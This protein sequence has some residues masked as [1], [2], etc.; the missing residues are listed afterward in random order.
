MPI[1]PELP[2]SFPLACSESQA[3][4]Q[5]QQ[6]LDW[7]DEINNTG[8]TVSAD[9]G[10]SKI[11]IGDTLA[12]RSKQLDATSG[13]VTEIVDTDQCNIQ[14]ANTSALSGAQS[15][16]NFIN[17][18]TVDTYGHVTA[19]GTG[20]WSFTLASDAGSCGTIVQSD[21]MTIVG[22]TEIDTTCGTD[23]VT[24]NH[25]DT[26]DLSGQYGLGDSIV[27]GSVTVDSLGHMTAVTTKDLGDGS[28]STVIYWNMQG[29]TGTNQ[30]VSNKQTADWE[31]GT[32]IK[33]VAKATRTL[34]ISFDPS[35]ITGHHATGFRVL[36]LEGNTLLWKTVEEML[37]KL[38]GW[39]ADDDESIGHDDGGDP[40]WQEDETC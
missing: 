40:A 23:S 18:V 20:S 14:H 26:S 5:T 9:S 19:V 16:G 31:G 12:I 15:G 2:G 36:C 34:E 30:K 3:R 4:S 37:K 24:V 10:S 17:S 21:T 35:K 28:S 29:D 38:G 25:S 13:I 22:G 1:K 33:T 7:I 39:T 6:I 27:I 32:A 11:E 8:F